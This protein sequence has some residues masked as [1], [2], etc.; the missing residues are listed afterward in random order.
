MPVNKINYCYFSLLLLLVNSFN[1][2]I[3]EPLTG[4]INGKQRY[5][6]DV[7]YKK[8]SVGEMVRE[9][10]YHNGEIKGKTT[11]N[12]SFLFYKM[13]GYQLSEMYWDEPSLSFLSK[14]F[15]YKETGSHK[16]N[17]TATFFD[18]GLQSKITTKGK[19]KEFKKEGAIVD[20]HAIGMQMSEGIRR[21]ETSFDFYMQTTEKVKHYYFEV[22]GK[23]TV[24]T[25]VGKFET[26]RLE[27]TRKNNRTLII[28][29]APEINYQMV[30][31]YY[32]FNLLDLRGIIKEYKQ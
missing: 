19:S 1:V 9:F 21:G 6:Y 17:T 10:D 24:D 12:L 31:F 18:N 11:A 4:L 28:W 8:V 22:K 27:Q 23:E 20:F 5:V 29:F 15:I 32:K 3:A 13:K 14:S 25:A 2:V 26:Y 16:E 30:K 7:F